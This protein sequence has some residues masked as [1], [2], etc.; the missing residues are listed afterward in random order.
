MG[1]AG[2][3]RALSVTVRPVPDQRFLLPRHGRGSDRGPAS[4]SRADDADRVPGYAGA[5]RRHPARGGA[6]DESA[7]APGTDL[8]FATDVEKRWI[9]LLDRTY[10]VGRRWPAAAELGRSKD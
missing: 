7:C 2:S 6:T 5:D 3:R 1:S 8:G 9:R 10:A 4:P